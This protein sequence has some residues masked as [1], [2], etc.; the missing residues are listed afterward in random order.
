VR[1]RIVVVVFFVTALAHVG[2]RA[3][4]R[5]RCQQR[6]P[7]T[8]RD[9]RRGHQRAPHACRTHAHAGACARAPR[10]SLVRSRMMG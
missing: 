5:A 8:A 2:K 6:S 1:R 3:G 4:R 9:P 7:G 10:P